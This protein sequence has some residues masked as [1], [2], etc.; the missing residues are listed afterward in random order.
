MCNC[1]FLVGVKELVCDICRPHNEIACMSE[2]K[3]KLTICL[4]FGPCINK[5]KTSKTISRK[6][7]G[8]CKWSS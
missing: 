8:T 4:E 2:E 7:R 3:C 6:K 1:C 5:K